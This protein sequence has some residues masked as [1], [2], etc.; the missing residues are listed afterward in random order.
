[1]VSPSHAIFALAGFL[2]AQ[3]HQSMDAG[4]IWFA[5]AVAGIGLWA[6]VRET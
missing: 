2:A 5:L 6:A 3:A 1:M 4:A